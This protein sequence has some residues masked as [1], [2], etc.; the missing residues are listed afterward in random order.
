MNWFKVAYDTEKIT[1]TIKLRF[2]K[3]SVTV[4]SWS[5]ITRICFLGGNV[6]KSDELYIFTDKRPESYVIPMEAD[7]VPQ[8]WD[9]I[10][11]RKLFD[12]E[13]AIKAAISLEGELLCWPPK[14]QD[15]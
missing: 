9:E 5:R 8:L 2:R 10:I 4:I 15:V 1:L 11:T 12:A 3:S 7:G 6:F 14:E 13:L